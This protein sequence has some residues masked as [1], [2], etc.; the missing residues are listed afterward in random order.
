MSTT[1][2][3]TASASQPPTASAE[4]GTGLIGSVV[5]ITVFLL[6]LLFAVQVL[7]RLYATSSLTAAGF[8][9]A[10]RVAATDVATRPAVVAQAEA[11][12]R[13]GLGSFGR[14]HTVFRWQRIDSEE[15]V[16][17]V[18]GRPPTFLPLPGWL[19]EIDRTVRVRTERFR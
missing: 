4:A 7:V 19:T 18:K 15:V 3:T 2:S 11:D 8:D 10:R 14:D 5:G 1:R 16:L 12:A 9:A 17:E 13:R 6:L